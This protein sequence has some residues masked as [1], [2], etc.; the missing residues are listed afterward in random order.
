MT[1]T[2]DC[3]ALH[4]SAHQWRGEFET[5]L[6]TAPPFPM[7]GPAKTPPLSGFTSKRN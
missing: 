2:Q 7:E 1:R 5:H 4:C 3:W 6:T